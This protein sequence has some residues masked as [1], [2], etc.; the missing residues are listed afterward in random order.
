MSYGY[1]VRLIESN[2][3]ADPK[4]LGVKLGRVC[5]KLCIPVSDVASTLGVSRQTVYNWFTGVNTP[6]NAVVGAVKDLIAS[7][8]QK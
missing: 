3:A 6:H 1:S 2:R 4:L 5:I 7:F 8:S